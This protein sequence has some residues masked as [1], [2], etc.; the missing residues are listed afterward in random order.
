MG[1]VLGYTRMLIRAYMRDWVALFFGFFFPL[2]FMGL[3]GILNFGS[4][5]HVS[6]GIVDNAN[7]ADSQAF[8]AGLKKI[9]TLQVQTG[10][11]AAQQDALRKGD[12]D[13]VLAIPADFKIAPARPGASV[14]QLTL[15]E[16]E[17]RGQQVAVGEAI[18]TQ[19]ID[20]MSFAV[21]QSAPI[22]TTRREQVQG[23]NLFVVDR[24]RGVIRR[25]MATPISRR[26]YMAAHVLERLILA[27]L[28]VGVLIAVAVLLFKVQ[29]VGSMAV[30]LLLT[31]LGSALF[32][33][34][35]FATSAFVT[36][37]QQAPAVMQLVTLPQM[38]LS[39][40]FFSRDVVP[41]FL[42][43]ISDYLPLTFLNDAL[44][45]VATAGASLVDIRGDLAG[46]VLWAA[47]TFVLAF[48][49]FRLET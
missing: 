8:I 33:C 10:N 38:F 19:V 48:R 12:L 24:Q 11:D 7:N 42:K 23:R 45:Q 35:G 29:I 15:F 2:I 41:S 18:L 16:N 14:P 13:I 47:V 26:A 31:V 17:G 49:F 4:F 3:F 6:L 22:L 28:Q 21:T 46:L 27:V 9:E 20:Q 30:L 34:L 37:E 32:L 40:V 1:Q 43:P 44:R 36:T 25:I 5:G 39:G